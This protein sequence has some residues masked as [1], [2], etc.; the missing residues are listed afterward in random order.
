[1]TQICSGD[2]LGRRPT[3][4]NVIR[5][6][7]PGNAADAVLAI[8]KLEAAIPPQAMTRHASLPFI[9]PRASV[10]PNLHPHGAG[11]KPQLDLA[12]EHAPAELLEPV[13]HLP[14]AHQQRRG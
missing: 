6:P 3:R 13:T 1:M 14:A 4:L 5:S 12:A 11:A 9:Y 2:G 10:V 8:A 7:L